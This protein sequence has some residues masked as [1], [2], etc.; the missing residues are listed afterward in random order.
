MNSTKVIKKLL[1]TVFVVFGLFVV[2][3]AS[4]SA[5]AVSTTKLQHAFIP[6]RDSQTGEVV[7]R[8]NNWSNMPFRG[9]ICAE[10]VMTSGRKNHIGC[11]MAD[12][13]SAW[14]SGT[15]S[16]QFGVPATMGSTIRYTYQDHSG[17]WYAIPGM[18]M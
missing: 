12:L 16:I 17:H 8:I 11:V 9:W 14:S 13:D 15:W 2:A 6:Q 1:L 7:A 18:R 10:E 4:S 5:Y 3:S